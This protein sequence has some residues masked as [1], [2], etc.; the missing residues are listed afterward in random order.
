MGENLPALNCQHKFYILAKKTS[1]HFHHR[2]VCPL[3]SFKL[4]QRYAVHLRIILTTSLQIQ[5]PKLIWFD[6]LN[7]VF[8]GWFLSI[9]VLYKDFKE[10]IISAGSLSTTLKSLSKIRVQNKSFRIH[11]P[12]RLS[13]WARCQTRAGPAPGGSPGSSPTKHSH[14]TRWPR[15]PLDAPRLESVLRINIYCYGDPDPASKKC[16]Y[17][18]VFK[19]VNTKEEKLPQIFFKMTLKND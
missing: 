4:P 19:S 7:S 12:T 11:N 9:I 14:R 16:P 1:P 6:N 3:D 2:L 15:L 17:G 8:C 10:L 18:S 13:S 5:A